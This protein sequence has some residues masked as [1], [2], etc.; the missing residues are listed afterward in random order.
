MKSRHGCEQLSPP[1][2][3]L[4]YTC[5]LAIRHPGR[6]A[7]EHDGQVIEW[8]DYV[9]PRIPVPKPDIMVMPG[10]VEGGREDFWRELGKVNHSVAYML[11]SR[12]RPWREWDGSTWVDHMWKLTPGTKFYDHTDDWTVLMVAETPVSVIIWTCER[13]DAPLVYGGDR[14]GRGGRGSRGPASVSLGD[15]VVLGAM[16]I[17]A[18]RKGEPF[19][20][21]WRDEFVPL[22]GCRS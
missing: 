6:H 9:E 17:L 13:M 3:D 8:E 15:S 10:R 16:K 2:D 4:R 18:R 11:H 21:V 12:E 1:R 14:L 20:G 5:S 19:K 7:M 22:M